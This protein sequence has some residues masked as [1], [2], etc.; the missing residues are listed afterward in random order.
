MYFIN[1]LQITDYLKYGIQPK[2]T[3][4]SLLF[5]KYHINYVQSTE[6]NIYLRMHELNGGFLGTIFRANYRPIGAID[7]EIQED[8]KTVE[9]KWWMI[10]NELHHKFS[11]GLYAP[12]L[13]D[14]DAH[15]VKQLLLSYAEDKARE[16]K[17]NKIK[18]DVHRSLN[19]YNYELKDNGFIL[20]N[21]R[22]DDHYYWLKTYKFLKES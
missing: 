15:D 1:F 9:I 2:T 5:P 22:A 7:L 16:Y 19:E 20:T 18:R 11:P 8:K 14:S 17:C 10:N 3:L 4:T 13:S 21:E 12:Q 6:K